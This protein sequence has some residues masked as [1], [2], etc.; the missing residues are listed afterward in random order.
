MTEIHTQSKF[1]LI[2][3]VIA[4]AGCGS[5]G[6]GGSGPTAASVSPNEANSGKTYPHWVPYLTEYYNPDGTLS[7]CIRGDLDSDGYLLSSTTSHPTQDE[8]HPVECS[9]DD[10]N[11]TYSEFTFDADRNE[12]STQTLSTFAP[13]VECQHVTLSAKSMPDRIE[14]FVSGSGNY[15]CSIQ[16]GRMFSLQL[17]TLEED[18]Y[19]TLTI[20]YGGPGSDNEWETADDTIQARYVS[21]WTPDRLTKVTVNYLG[22]GTDNTW[23]TGDDLITGIVET[24]FKSDMIPDHSY[25][26]APGADGLPNTGD[27][28]VMGYTVYTYENGDIKSHSAYSSAGLDGDWE[29]VADNTKQYTVFY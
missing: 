26:R 8:N 1:I 6:G 11:T 2:M 24:V 9:D 27:D 23:E 18:L 19:E 10:L 29:T 17:V 3:G 14:T 20:S 5:G 16:D 13:Y 25:T 15:T 21:T 22:P 12:F 4:L 7:S 28:V